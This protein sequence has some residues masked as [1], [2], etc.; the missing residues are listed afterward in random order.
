[1]NKNG[2]FTKRFL[3]R[4]IL[5]DLIEF[6]CVKS[7]F[8]LHFVGDVNAFSRVHSRRRSRFSEETLILHRPWELPM[9]LSM[10]RT[11]MDPTCCYYQEIMSN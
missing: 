11:A 1:M 9:Y 4:S 2:H 10:G 8:S 6:F 3:G 5:L 7:M